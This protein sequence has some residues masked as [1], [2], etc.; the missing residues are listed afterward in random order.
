MAP[1]RRASLLNATPPSSPAPAGSPGPLPDAPSL[2]APDDRPLRRVDFI[3]EPFRQPSDA[4]ASWQLLTT[5]APV[6]GL[7]TGVAWLGQAQLGLPRLALALLPVL[8]LLVLFSARTF[9]LMHDCGHN[10]LF[11]HRWLNRATGFGLGVLNAIPQHPWSRGHAFHHRH[12]GNWER[13]RGPSALVTLEHYRGL[14]PRQ[15]WVYGVLRQPLML[16]PGGFFYLVIKPRL[17]LLLGAGEFVIAMARATA[18]AVGARGWRALAELPALVRQ[19]R[20]SH[21]YTGGELA[22]LVANNLLV[23][24]SWWWMVRW[25]GA[26]LFLSCYALVMACSAAIFICIFFVQ[27][28]FA[29]TYA[30][31]TADWNYLRGAVEGS[32]NLELPPILHWFSADI[33]FH[34]I[35]HLCER[36]PNYRL[37][38]C[39]ERNAHL[40][41]AA[42]RLR[43]VD[44]PG[45]FAYILWDHTNNRLITLAEAAEAT[46]V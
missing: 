28:N 27:H 4:R 18:V 15:R 34:S 44:I 21:W 26:G 20:S 2:P 7:W 39:H 38:A 13:Y 46:P 11:R 12:N 35:H 5:L 30:H 6:A 19:H 32:S 1:E 36:I 37:R 25:L 41:R 40:L 24:A 9:S 14:P 43:L 3:L 31:G 8:A 17:A 33:G 45:C 42:R 10:S 23:I 29:D 22:D 16:L